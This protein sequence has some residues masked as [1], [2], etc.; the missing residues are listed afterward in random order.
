M[1]LAIFLL[2]RHIQIVTSCSSHSFS[3]YAKQSLFI[4]VLIISNKMATLQ[5][6]LNLSNLRSFLVLIFAVVRFGENEE[7][8][9]AED[10]QQV[11]TIINP[12]VV[13]QFFETIYTSIFKGFFITEITNGGFLGSVSTYF[14]TI[15][16]N[17][18]GILYLHCLIGL[19]NVYYL[20]KFHD[21]LQSNP[22][23]TIEMVKLIDNI[24]CYLIGNIMS[25]K[26]IKSEALSAN[27]EETNKNLLSNCIRTVML[28]P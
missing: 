4:K 19:Y 9:S 28:S 26:N 21:Q 5:I 20:A 14:E 6:K 18:Q 22:I 1:N 11:T 17:S 23:Y 27:V 24:V 15:E 10:F 13:T 2:E 8:T 25:S 12:V 7:T 3:K 16:M